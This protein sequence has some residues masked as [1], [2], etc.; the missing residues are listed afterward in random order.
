VKS[1]PAFAA[2]ALALLAAAQTALAQDRG[3]EV[4]DLDT[5]LRTHPLPPGDS[6]DVVASRRSGKGELQI[7]RVRKIPLHIH[8]QDHVVFIERGTGWPGS[9][10]PPARSRPGR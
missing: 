2:A 9:R 4:M 3:I 7:V 6:A 1:G 10:T 5:I 8:D